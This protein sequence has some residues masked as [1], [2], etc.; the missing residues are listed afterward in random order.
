MFVQRLKSWALNP[1]ATWDLTASYRGGLGATA[2]ESAAQVVANAVSASKVTRISDRAIL[3]KSDRHVF[4]VRLFSL[5]EA[6]PEEDCSL[7]IQLQ[8][9]RVGYRSSVRTLDHEVLPVFQAAEQA[10]RPEGRT[11][12]LRI[13]YDKPNPFYGA[14]VQ[15]LGLIS[16]EAFNLTFRHRGDTV[17]V[18]KETLTVRADGLI[19]FRSL[20]AEHLGAFGGAL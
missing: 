17:T 6:C 15:Q 14:Y 18:S 10:L 9:L 12:F 2:L 16:I 13:L 11:Y 5:G 1:D 8:S 7:E 20:A 3:V 19:A 4:E